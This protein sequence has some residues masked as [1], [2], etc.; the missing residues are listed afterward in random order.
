MKKIIYQALFFIPL[1]LIVTDGIGQ[2]KPKKI[3]KDIKKLDA[4]TISNKISI[5]TT[6]IKLIYP[7][8]YCPTKTSTPTFQWESLKSFKSKAIITYEFTLV[9]MNLTDTTMDDFDKRRIIVNIKGLKNNTLTFPQNI[10]K[11]EMR[12]LYGWQVKQYE[13][14]ILTYIS[15]PLPF[16]IIDYKLPFDTNEV[17]CCQNNIVKNGDFMENTVKGKLGNGGKSSNW[18]NAYGSPY[19]VNSEDGCGT[20]NYIMITGSNKNGDAIA[21]NVNILK[22]KHYRLT[23]CV[24]ICKEMKN[25]DYVYVN[26]VAFNGTLPSSGIHP[27]PSSTISK[28][29]WSGKIKSKEWITISLPV[30]TPIKDFQNIAI[31]CSTESEELSACFEIDK[32]CL[33]ETNDNSSCDD[34]S[35]NEEG[36]VIIPDDLTQNAGKIDTT[37]YETKNGKLIDLYEGYDGT[38]SFYKPNDE[39]AS[40]GGEIPESILKYNAD[41]AL[42]ELGI[43]ISVE[44]LEEI[45]KTEYKDNSLETKLK[46]IGGLKNQKCERSYTPNANLPFSGRDIIFVHGLNLTHLCER[47]SEM[48]DAQQDWPKDKSAFYGKGYYKTLATNTWKDHIQE[49]LRNKG[50]N[51]RVL[52]VA[53]NCSQRAEVAAHS[54]LTQI[55]DA[56]NDGADVD[57]V[58]G[59]IRENKCFGRDAVIISHS[60]GGLVTDIA[61]SLAEK[62][63]YDPIIKKRFG[64]IGF[65]PNNIKLHIGLHAAFRGS[66]MAS[67]YV[68]SQTIPVINTLFASNTACKDFSIDGLEMS[69]VTLSSILIDL[70]PSVATA[71]WMPIISTSP[72]STITIAGGHSFGVPELVPLMNVAIHPGLDDGVL[73]MGSQSANPWFETGVNPVGYIRQPGIYKLYDLGINHGIGT[74]ANQY[75]LNQT[76]FCSP[77]FV[78]G[79]STAYLSPTGMVQPVLSIPFLSNPE[80]RLPNHFSFLQST[81][82]HYRGPRGKS[83]SEGYNPSFHN[84]TS[85]FKSLNYDYHNANGRHWEESLVITDNRVF[86]KGFINPAVLNLPEEITKGEYI[87][88]DVYGPQFSFKCCP[89]PRFRMWWG[90]MFHVRIPIWERKYH[91]MSDSDT[92]S[93]CSYIYKYVLR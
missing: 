47:A 37:Y 22:G 62:S 27:S 35:Y 45:L 68:A 80:N 78:G 29:G 74:R 7:T 57:F 19:V 33:Q 14:N 1:M 85:G 76:L 64:N 81:S 6:A 67:I 66:K 10:Q 30:W 90:P 13:N 25:I 77:L 58:K 51:N 12:K 75:F 69:K 34:Y 32:I 18:V 39:C 42:K 44:E 92:E 60:T 71:I 52:V 43:N 38:T 24:K 26:A 82:D 79:T 3:Y 72:I 9:E 83:I 59:D 4:K 23:A 11:L 86:S 15:M 31:Y 20:P 61:M 21:Q 8:P 89:R 73:T 36:K 56:M 70:Q 50:Y 16:Y 2:I 5:D 48:K 87:D 55:K 91:L 54:I 53:Y 93:E 17:L 46:P 84:S 28:I 41:D 65:I 49:W 40:I 88:F 63:K